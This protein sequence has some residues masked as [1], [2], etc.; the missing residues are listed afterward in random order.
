MA[1]PLGIGG[2]VRRRL[3]R[4]AAGWNDDGR[5]DVRSLLLA[6]IGSLA[7]LFS[8]RSS[9]CTRWHETIA[10]DRRRTGTNTPIN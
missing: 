10:G 2:A 6:I 5:V 7:V 1:I 8:Y 3:D 9:R 4:L